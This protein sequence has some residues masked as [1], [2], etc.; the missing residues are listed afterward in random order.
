TDVPLSAADTSAFLAMLQL[1][2][3][4][5]DAAA[6][7]VE[8]AMNDEPANPLVIAAAAQIDL[9]RHDSE[10]AE[11]RL[12]AVTPPAD[13]FAAYAA[14]V[15]L[16]EAAEEERDDASETRAKALSLLRRADAGHAG[17]PNILAHRVRIEMLGDAP[18]SADAK[19][20]IA[21]ART[22]APGRIEYAL[23]HAELL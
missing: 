15:G 12:S 3:L 22:L 11:R 16:A 23:L 7:L 21:R 18:P 17:L 9:V 14:G 8:S 4:G 19:A 6:K 13:W 2:N 20:D 1:R 5:A 10:R